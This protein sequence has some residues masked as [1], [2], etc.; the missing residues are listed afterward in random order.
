[1]DR[2]ITSTS[3]VESSRGNEHTITFKL[4]DKLVISRVF[5]YPRTTKQNHNVGDTE[6]LVGVNH[7]QRRCGNV[8]KG[9][10]LDK[11][12]V[13]FQC[14]SIVGERGDT[15]QVRLSGNKRSILSLYEV[16]IY[17]FP[18]DLEVLLVESQSLENQALEHSVL[19]PYKRVLK[20]VRNIAARPVFQKWDNEDMFLTY[21]RPSDSWHFKTARMLGSSKA[22]VI[23]RGQYKSHTPIEA[24]ETC[25][26]YTHFPT[27]WQFDKCSNPITFRKV[28]IHRYITVSNGFKNAGPLSSILNGE[29]E[30]VP[31]QKFRFP[32]SGGRPVYQNERW[33]YIYLHYDADE[34]QWAFTEIHSSDSGKDVSY[35]TAYVAF[36]KPS[37]TPDNSKWYKCVRLEQNGVEKSCGGSVEFQGHGPTVSH[38]DYNF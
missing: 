36:K 2:E 18:A 30:L 5:V 37:L 27:G 6:V 19:G 23:L 31:D 21:Y 22:L 3:F 20:K 34:V 24:N 35:P 17:A 14:N 28:P 7:E 10:M 38:F 11:N 26:A 15:V 33:R 16:E 12:P 8:M 9:Q 1:M 25:I 4:N 32:K 13:L 29:Y